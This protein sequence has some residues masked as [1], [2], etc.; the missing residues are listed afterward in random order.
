MRLGSKHHSAVIGYTI[1]LSPDM[2]PGEEPL[3]LG[4]A[5]TVEIGDV[6]ISAGSVQRSGRVIAFE[7]GGGTAW[8]DCLLRLVAPT[9]KGEAI[10]HDLEVF[11]L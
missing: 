9:S 2:A 3:D 4:L 8:T 10:V 5:V 11:V 7:L 1:D 6:V